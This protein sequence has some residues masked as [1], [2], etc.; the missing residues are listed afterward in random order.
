MLM[1]PNEKKTLPALAILAALLGALPSVPAHAATSDWVDAARQSAVVATATVTDA[2]I[3]VSYPDDVG[4]VISPG[5]GLEV[6][7]GLF[8]TAIVHGAAPAVGRIVRFTVE[9]AYKSDGAA[10]AGSTVDVYFD[11]SRYGIGTPLPA[12]TG[13]KWLLFLR[14][15]ME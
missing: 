8:E 12:H 7:P 15:P 11:A 5:S 9:T 1:L 10:A 3:T 4:A 2:D 6:S 13:E 14:R